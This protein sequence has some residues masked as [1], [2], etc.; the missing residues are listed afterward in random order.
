MLLLIKKLFKPIAYLLLLTS[1]I[2]FLPVKAH[3]GLCDF[4]GNVPDP[5]YWNK[6]EFTDLLIYNENMPGY[7][8]THLSFVIGQLAMADS[9]ILNSSSCKVSR[10]VVAL[11]EF[12]DKHKETIKEKHPEV[13]DLIE[14]IKLKVKNTPE[15]F[16]G[17][18]YEGL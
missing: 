17:E 12:Y 10:Y 15:T 6:Y 1:V 18:K 4:N 14:F 13:A 16:R 8:I 3:K 7:L 9:A 2:C 11:I 5:E